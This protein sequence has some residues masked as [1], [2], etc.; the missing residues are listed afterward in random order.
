MK[1]RWILGRL[2]KYCFNNNGFAMGSMIIASILL[3]LL[4]VLQIWI[5]GQI[6][7]GLGSLSGQRKEL[8]LYMIML[9]VCLLLWKIC[10]ILIPYV[11]NNLVSKMKIR[12]QKDLIESVNKIPVIQ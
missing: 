1:K 11:R 3:G 4:S 6:V 7:N 12:M 10:F 5:V 9:L 8:I 2:I